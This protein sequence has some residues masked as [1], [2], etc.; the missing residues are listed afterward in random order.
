MG[1]DQQN[2]ILANNRFFQPS[3]IT[4]IEDEAIAKLEEKI[5]AKKDELALLN[6]WAKNTKEEQLTKQIKELEDD[7]KKYQSEIG[8]VMFFDGGGLQEINL[9]N[10]VKLSSALNIIKNNFKVVEQ[11]AVAAQYL[12]ALINAI[13]IAYASSAVE[14]HLSEEEQGKQVILISTTFIIGKLISVIAIVD[15]MLK[16]FTAQL[17]KLKQKKLLAKIMLDL[18]KKGICKTDSTNARHQNKIDLGITA[19]EKNIQGLD[20]IKS[21]LNLIVE[22]INRKIHHANEYWQEGHEFSK[23]YFLEDDLIKLD[24]LYNPFFEHMAK[25]LK[26]YES[27][28]ADVLEVIVELN[29]VSKKLSNLAV[30]LTLTFEFVMAT[31]NKAYQVTNSLKRTVEATIA[32]HKNRHQV[33]KKAYDQVSPV[34]NKIQNTL[35]GQNRAKDALDKDKSKIDSEETDYKEL[36]KTH[37]QLRKMIEKIN[38]Y[39]FLQVAPD[40]VVRP[41]FTLQ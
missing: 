5:S 30:A 24:L 1:K 19:L 3:H 9:V 36:I 22:S 20:N 13:R 16:E 40:P 15:N 38:T 39:D 26:K 28:S 7:I 17:E 8:N 14:E 34:T 37:E 23:R 12:E 6:E 35:M 2:R 10:N 25:F 41:R 11:S 33:L 32:L 4:I 31:L 21:Y 18:T 29:K 27:I